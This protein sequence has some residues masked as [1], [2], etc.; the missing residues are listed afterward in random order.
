MEST[1][2]INET[3]SSVKLTKNSKGWGW[4]IKIYDM[5]PDNILKQVKKL[6]DELTADYSD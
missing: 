6:N 4:E 1:K 3:E 2:I 5:N